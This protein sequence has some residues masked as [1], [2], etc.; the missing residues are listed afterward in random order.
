MT[1]TVDTVNDRGVGEGDSI[2]INYR[3]THNDP[4]TV[5]CK[6]TVYDYDIMTCDICKAGGIGGTGPE[7][8]Y[9]R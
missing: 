3:H 8:G 1:H 6:D 2:Y 9:S 5:L 7:R 4:H